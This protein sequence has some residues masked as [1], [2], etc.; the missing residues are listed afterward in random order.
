MIDVFVVF[1]KFIYPFIHGSVGSPFL[2]EGFP[3]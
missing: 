2:C 3:Q 1:L